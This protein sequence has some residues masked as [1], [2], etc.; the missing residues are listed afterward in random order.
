MGTF[1]PRSPVEHLAADSGIGTGI[2]FSSYLFYK[3]A[4]VRSGGTTAGV[5]SF[6]HRRLSELG[7]EE[8]LIHAHLSGKQDHKPEQLDFHK[9][10][11]YSVFTPLV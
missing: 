3:G 5:N 7:L 4:P 2:Y 8:A 11:C 10:I 9:G 6:L 1:Y